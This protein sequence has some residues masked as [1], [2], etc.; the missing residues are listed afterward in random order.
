MPAKKV[1]LDFLE[2]G[3]EGKTLALK[4]GTISKST[5]VYICILVILAFSVANIAG[6]TYETFN[7]LD[8]KGEAK[9]KEC[10]LDYIGKS[11]KTL[12]PTDDCS[13][14]LKCVTDVGDDLG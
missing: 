13:S 3:E 9:V 8:K 7:I 4:G 5:K 10:L 1:S 14:L 11:C 2:K 6:E 12:N